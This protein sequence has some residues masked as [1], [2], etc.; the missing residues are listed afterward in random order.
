MRGGKRG[1]RGGGSASG[2]ENHSGGEVKNDLSASSPPSSLSSRTLAGQSATTSETDGRVEEVEAKTYFSMAKLI[3]KKFAAG[4]SKRVNGAVSHSNALVLKRGGANGRRGG[5]P[6]FVN[7]L[8]EMLWKPQGA[9]GPHDGVASGWYEGWGWD[10]V[11]GNWKT[12]SS[13]QRRKFEK[14]IR[15]S[16][17]DFALKDLL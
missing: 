3:S 9:G 7:N 17:E 16:N 10:E 11:K 6:N 1:G 14:A 12:F 15:N 8:N 2:G 4:R 13:R 5:A